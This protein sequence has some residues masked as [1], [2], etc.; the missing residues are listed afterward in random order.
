MITLNA[1]IN[2]CIVVH[3]CVY[4]VT[5]MLY[6][7]ITACV[8]VISYTVKLKKGYLCKQTVHVAI[9]NTFTPPESMCTGLHDYL[10]FCSPRDLRAHISQT[11]SVHV[12]T[13][14]C[15]TFAPKINGIQRV[16][17]LMSPWFEGNIF[18]EPGPRASGCTY[19]ADHS[20]PYYKY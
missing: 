19:Q 20:C 3:A 1:S 6:L 7:L 14:K 5:I 11:S 15:N 10:I 4:T 16:T 9:C 17:Y 13:T 18:D 2:V 12:T 8:H